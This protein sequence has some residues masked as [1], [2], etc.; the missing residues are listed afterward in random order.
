M[1]RMKEFLPK[2][3]AASRCP[4]EIDPESL[5]TDCDWLFACIQTLYRMD[6]RGRITQS[7]NANC[8]PAPI[9]CLGLTHHGNL[10]RVAERLPS[11]VARRAARLAGREQVLPPTPPP[12]PPCERRA[13]LRKV[14]GVSASRH[15]DT[16]WVC[17]RMPSAQA[18]R[19]IPR[20]GS[21]SISR[22]CT[23]TE[24]PSESVFGW[25]ARFAEATPD[26]SRVVALERDRI[27]SACGLLAGD[28]SHFVVPWVE[29]GAAWQRRGQAR[30]VLALWLAGVEQKGGI[31][32]YMAD[33]RNRGAIAL[34]SSL[35]LEAFA[36]LNLWF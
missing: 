24:I 35:D 3:G 7:S 29:T 1:V 14:L 31:P 16:E 30:R 15:L 6:Q 36:A 5:Q 12:W 10:W 4:H 18:L 11:A 19:S 22:L 8:G 33:S 2:E 25:S 32:I 26:G 28:R 13:A 21:N 20:R 27:V 34:A 23:G 17:F 9:F